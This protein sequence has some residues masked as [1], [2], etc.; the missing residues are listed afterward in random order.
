MWFIVKSLQQLIFRNGGSTNLGNE[1]QCLAV[2]KAPM[3]STVTGPLLHTVRARINGQI[4]MNSGSSTIF[5]LQYPTYSV[6]STVPR[7]VFCATVFGVSP[8]PPL[9]SKMYLYT[10]VCDP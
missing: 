9:H 8:L 7:T 4:C 3:N 10:S 5:G 6:R 1:I 2:S